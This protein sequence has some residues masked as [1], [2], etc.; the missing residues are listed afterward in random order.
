MKI[1]YKKILERKSLINCIHLQKIS[2]L[3]KKIHISY[4]EHKST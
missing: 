3:L 2:L 4:D 1:C